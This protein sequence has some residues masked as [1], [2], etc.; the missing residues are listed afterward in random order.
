MCAVTAPMENGEV[1]SLGEVSVEV[2]LTRHPAT[3]DKKI[4]VKGNWY[5]AILTSLL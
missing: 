5:T 1:E 4:T 3:D 2:T